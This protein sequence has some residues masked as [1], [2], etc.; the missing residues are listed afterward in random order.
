[1]LA[2]GIDYVPRP[3]PVEAPP[4]HP[5]APVEPSL[6]AAPTDESLEQIRTDLGECVRCRLSE[7]RTRMIEAV[8]WQRGEVYI[9][10]IVKCRPPG[11][12][13]PQIDEVAI[14]RPFLERQ[15]RAIQPRVILTLG[16]PAATTLLGRPVAITKVRGIW[17]DWEGIPLMPTFHPAYLLRNYTRETRQAVW[18]DLRAVRARVEEDPES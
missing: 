12:R 15:L 7:E 8:G 9:C 11:N 16:K 10:N 6:F 17:H 3:G 5:S 14:C 4:V 18:D 13:A 2:D 1:L